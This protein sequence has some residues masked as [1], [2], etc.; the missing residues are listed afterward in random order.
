MFRCRFVVVWVAQQLCSV[1][2]VFVVFILF[3]WF[4]WGGVASCSSPVWCV[5]LF[6]LVVGSSLLTFWVG[7]YVLSCRFLFFVLLILFCVASSFY[8][9]CLL[10]TV[11][12]VSRFPS[13]GFGWFYVW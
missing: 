6:F 9:L 5:F 1:H 8:L 11:S 12:G 4:L 2:S 7:V 13:R 10:Q 3:L